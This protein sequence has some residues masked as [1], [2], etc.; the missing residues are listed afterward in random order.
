MVSREAFWYRERV[1]N[2]IRMTWKEIHGDRRRHGQVDVRKGI[3]LSPRMIDALRIEHVQLAFDMPES[4]SKDD[5]TIS[6]NEFVKLLIKV[7]NASQE[8][9]SLM[10][11]LQPLL[12]DQPHNIATD[13]S[14]RFLWTGVLQKAIRPVIEPGQ[15]EISEL[16]VIGLV[17]GVYEVN[18]TVEDLKAAKPGVDGLTSSERRIWHARK[19]ALIHVVDS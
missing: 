15:T 1:V 10:L 12:H 14:K 16:E 3:R 18:A 5:F 13:L 4:I 11:R 2:N 8:D 7:H 17:P 6:R 19:P 9:L